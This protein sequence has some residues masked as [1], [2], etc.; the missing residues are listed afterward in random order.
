M[1]ESTAG[2]SA[3]S[4]A[5]STLVSRASVLRPG[6]YAAI[7]IGTVTCRMLVADID[8]MGNVNELT[9]EYAI[10]NLGEGVDATGLLKSDAIDRVAAV[11]SG[12]IDIRDSFSTA[13]HPVL[14][15]IAV[16]TSASRDARNAGE[17]VSALRRI[18]IELA[19]IPGEKEAG[20]SFAGASCDFT[21]QTLMVVDIGGGSTE[22]VV[23]KAAE[24][25]RWTHSF[26]VGCRRVTERFL[27]ADPPSEG[28]LH[29]ARSWIREEMEGLLAE[30]E[31][32]VDGSYELVAVAGTATTVVTVRDAVAVYDS[33]LV[34][35]QR[36]TRKELDD[37]FE[38]LRAMP[39]DQRAKVV[40]LDPGRAPVI[41]AGLMIMQVVMDLAGA[42]SFVVSETDILHGMV[43]DAASMRD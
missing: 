3:P 29:Q 34:H 23:G 9:C 40:G 30:A 20:L 2:S 38:M 35:K 17:F 25:P 41:V 36:V 16:A 43:L 24:R 10:T 33:A 37:Q 31:E 26:N 14:E 11:L 32:S 4:S 18:G 8:E 12:F 6:R 19:V 42:D 15:T 5:S 22:V 39:N 13:D 27:L 28:E 21:G 1:S 7:D